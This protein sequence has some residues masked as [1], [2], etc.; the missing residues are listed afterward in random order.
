METKLK[1][2]KRRKVFHLFVGV[3]TLRLT[4]LKI[5]FHVAFGHGPRLS[6]LNSLINV[7]I[8]FKCNNYLAGLFTYIHMF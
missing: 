7:P 8:C 6:Q 5:P 2:A 3:E 4:V 1:A